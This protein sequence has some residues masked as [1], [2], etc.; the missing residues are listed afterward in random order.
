MLVIPP[1]ARH[2]LVTALFV[3]GAAGCGEVGDRPQGGKSESQPASK[4][5]PDRLP[6]TASSE[7]LNFRNQWV[8]PAF[9][10]L[11]LSTV[12]RDCAP[13]TEGLPTRVNSVDYLYGS[14]DPGKGSEGGCAVPL[15]I[16]SW[17]AEVRS[18][19]LYE[20][21]PEELQIPRQDTTVN[22]AA[23]SVFEGGR[24]LEIFYEDVTVV[25][26]GQ[27]RDH[28]DRVANALEDGPSRLTDLEQYG[29]VFP[30]NCVDDPHYCEAQPGR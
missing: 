22:G 19:E 6:C 12:I 4:T 16:Q 28:V 21:G 14:C 27:G 7:D 13:P 23:A 3:V 26:F 1:T 5:E 10:G 29:L 18:N 24:R 11:E 20:M 9:E 8:G 15:E 17:P 25:I 30:E 2:L